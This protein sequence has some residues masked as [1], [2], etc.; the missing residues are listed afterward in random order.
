MATLEE[1]IRQRLA[2]ATTQVEEA[3][4]L[5]V[6]KD[7]AP[8]EVGKTDEIEL[9]PKKK[10][11]C[12]EDLDEMTQEEF[13]SIDEEQLD[14][15]SKTTLGN[16]IKKAEK[17][18]VKSNL[19]SLKHDDKADD[20]YNRATNVPGAATTDKGAQKY[21]DLMHRSYDETDK[22]AKS[23]D[24]AIKRRKN[25]DKASNKLGEDTVS[26]QVS[27][28][29]EAEGLSEDFKV[30]AVTIFEAAVTDRVLQ[31]EEELKQEFD[32]QLA[33]AKA[34]L[35][36]DIDGFL[37]EAI[38]QWKQDN[39]VAIKSNFKSQLAESFMDGM[40]ALIAEHN[41][42][43]PEDKE[44]ALEVALGEVDKLNESILA[45]EAEMLSLQEKV[46]EMK[47]EQILESF[48]EK[49]TQT[50]FDRFVQL[51]ESVQFKDEAQYE[52]QLTVVLENF[53][54]KQKVTKVADPIVEVVSEAVHKI[55]TE[56]NSDMDVYTKYL[57]TKQL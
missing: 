33:E 14:E 27:A 49:M 11:L 47:A 51:T 35:D 22:G 54:S 26:S 13:D 1:V 4:K 38:Q 12:K 44:D 52:K 41:I 7:V 48:K 21:S 6:I 8:E 29:L 20:L 19:K 18:V 34:E 25:I 45:K 53:G 57:K 10:S 16:Y 17:S 40:K 15:L 36:N 31:I 5:A 55:V 50:E 3:K 42:E 24:D 56:S 37:S 9:N 23:Y 30:Q 43:V 28:L 2:E 39:E 32:S 46:N